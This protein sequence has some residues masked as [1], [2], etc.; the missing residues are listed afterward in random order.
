MDNLQTINCQIDSEH[1][2]DPK[3]ALAV[4]SLAV[5]GILFYFLSGTPVA[6]HRQVADHS[7]VQQ[8][9]R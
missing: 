3:M 5:I 2:E 8:G 4:L 7:R 6:D 1:G 9:I